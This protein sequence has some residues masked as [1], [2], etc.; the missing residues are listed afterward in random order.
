MSVI[1]CVT[2]VGKTVALSWINSKALKQS[3]RENIQSFVMLVDLLYSPAV[4]WYR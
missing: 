3:V 4:G 2:A 1:S